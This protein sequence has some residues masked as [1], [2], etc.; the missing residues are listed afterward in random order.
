LIKRI[1]S[2][3]DLTWTEVDKI[4]KETEAV[5]IPCG[6]VE[7]HG[8]HLP[9]G[10]DSLIGLEVALRVAERL[11]GEGRK[12]LIAPPV[13]FG[14][15]EMLMSFPG[16]IS[17]KP[18]TLKMLICD[19]CTSFAKHGF[20]KIFLFPGHRSPKEV[21]V[22]NDAAISVSQETGAEVHVVDP[23][24]KWVNDSID[25]IK[26]KKPE[27]DYHAGERET[28]S[29]LASKPELVK[30]EHAR[31]FISKKLGMNIRT[32]LSDLRELA[33]MGFAGDPTVATAETGNRLY[34]IQVGEVSSLI[35][36]VL[37]KK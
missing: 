17:V 32:K 16:T 14:I 11:E 4:R 27:F 5:I 24:D 6:S 20:R 34:E 18:E 33:P 37:D 25:F 22:L 31:K 35:R 26:S 8:P 2:I 3:F 13:I 21:Q 28:A 30:M 29:I 12:I 36:R 1:T 7:E 15:S 23:F 9:L 10:T 19:I